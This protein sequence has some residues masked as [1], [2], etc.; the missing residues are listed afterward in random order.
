MSQEQQAQTTAPAA[1]DT[2]TSWNFGDFAKGFQTPFTKGENGYNLAGALLVGGGT[3]L[4]TWVLSRMLGIKGGPSLGISILAALA[5]THGALAKQGGSGFLSNPKDYLKDIMDWKRSGNMASNG[6]NTDKSV[7]T[8]LSTNTPVNQGV[9]SQGAASQGTATKEINRSAAPQTTVQKTGQPGGDT[10]RNAQGDEI[11]YIQLANQML[12]S[13][14]IQKGDMRN[15]TDADLTRFVEYARNNPVFREGKYP[16]AYNLYQAAENELSEREKLKAA[17]GF[18][19]MNQQAIMW[20]GGDKNLTPNNL[21]NVSI[22]HLNRFIANVDKPQ[23]A[24]F[25]NTDWYPAVN[26]ELSRRT[27][28]KRIKTY[29]PYPLKPTP[30]FPAWEDYF[31]RQFEDK[32]KNWNNPSFIPDGPYK[33]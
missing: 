16:S 32:S 27:T 14:S 10:Q 8:D 1:D 31:D 24:H 26:D 11:K 20:L 17:V 4:A 19:T 29:F 33:S 18:N 9:V 13:P 30:G 7:N 25:K 21:K 23:Y 22:G 12:K 6:G 15:V 5:G 3:G 28:P 2:K